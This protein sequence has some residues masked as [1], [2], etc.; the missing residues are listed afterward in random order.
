M[1]QICY[2]F[3]VSFYLVLL[4]FGANSA[5]KWTVLPHSLTQAFTSEHSIFSFQNSDG[6]FWKES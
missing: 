6:H 4:E 5:R 3:E 1:I 2:F